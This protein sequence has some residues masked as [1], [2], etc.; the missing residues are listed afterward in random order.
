MPIRHCQRCGLKVVVGDA[1][2]APSPL[3]CQTCQAAAAA[4]PPPRPAVL[5]PPPKPPRVEEKTAVAAP[6]P[7][8]GASEIF[9]RAEPPP[10]PTAEPGSDAAAETWRYYARLERDVREV[11][12]WVEWDLRHFPVYSS[13]LGMLLVRAGHEA[14]VLL[15]E[16]HEKAGGVSGPG[17]PLPEL[18]RALESAYRLSRVRIALRRV[19]RSTT[20]F[21][22]HVYAPFEGFERNAPP[23]WWEACELSRKSRHEHASRGSFENVVKALGAVLWLNLLNLKPASSD[24]VPM[25]FPALEIPHPLFELQAVSDAPGSLRLDPSRSL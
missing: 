12:S 10:A 13:Q 5:P 18:Q 23:P 14:E 4:A 1:Q 6:P 24:R 9:P 11:L 2:S 22:H 16:L 15:R 17:A 8:R 25:P 21:G 3:Y 19:D 7:P 20:P